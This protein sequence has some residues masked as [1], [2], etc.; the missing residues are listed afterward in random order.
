[1]GAEA[2][3]TATFKGQSSTGKARLETDVLQFR[4][5]E[6]R[7]SIPFK[8]IEK[9][10]SCKGVLAVTFG[11]DTAHF[12]LGAA[13]TKWAGKIKV[14]G[15]ISSQQTLATAFPK[16]APALR[17][18]FNAYLRDIKTSGVYDRLV[19]KYYPGIRRFFPEFFAKTNG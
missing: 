2:T 8:T 16:D 11:G 1:M 14:L 15:P 7:L 10:S 4:G 19:D 6:L 12:D 18:E 17:D 13:S 3:C 9:V 5:N